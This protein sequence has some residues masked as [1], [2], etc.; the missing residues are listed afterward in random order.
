MDTKARVAPEFSSVVYNIQPSQWTPVDVVALSK[1][2]AWQLA[3]NVEMEVVRF[4]LLQN[5]TSLDRVNQIYPVY[6]SDGPVVLTTEDLNIHLT[7]EEIAALEKKFQ[8]DSG[9]FIPKVNK[10]KKPRTAYTMSAYETMGKVVQ[11]LFGSQKASNAWVVGGKFTST[12]GPVLANDPHM[13]FTAPGAFIL[14]HLESQESNLNTIG[15]SLVGIPGIYIGENA[16]ISWGLTNSAAD[17]QD[18]YVMSD[19]DG[20]VTSS[21]KYQYKGQAQNYNSTQETI[22]VKGSQNVVI[23]VKESVY[24]PVVNSLFDISES[25][26]ICLSYAGSTSSDLS[27]VTYLRIMRANNWNDFTAAVS[28]LAGPSYNF[29]YG[30]RNGNIGFATGGKI[31]IRKEGHSGRFPVPGT[32]DWDY[33]GF[34]PWNEMPVVFN[35]S[36]SYVVAA[37]NRVTPPG[38]KY[39]L[40]LDWESKYRAERI[41][42]HLNTMLPFSNVTVEEMKNLQMDVK[43][44]IFEEFKFIWPIIAGNLS[45]DAEG[46]REKLQAWDGKLSEGLEVPAI[47]EA[48]FGEM[49]RI[50]EQEIGVSLD[51]RYPMF[52]REVLKN[53]DLICLNSHNTTCTLYAARALNNSVA[54]LGEVFGGTA[55]L[56]GTDVHEVQF[57]HLSL[58][59][60]ALKCMA[61]KTVFNIGGSET[62]NVGDTTYPELKTFSGVTYRQVI[63]LSKNSTAAISDY[64]IIPLGQSGNWLA[65]TYDN[66]LY[67][68]R[69]GTYLDMKVAGYNKAA[70]LNLKA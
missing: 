32:G 46:W 15:A 54:A 58:G 25:S 8:N 23:T 13:A 61:T 5:G 4:K 9:A 26:S 18:L 44:M 41:V 42:Q 20:N 49:C 40:T 65:N 52:I 31:P 66:Y 57:N 33:L 51:K 50:T 59:D 56:W 10:N 37:N 1:A 62:V 64:F 39:S 68:W 3:L 70:V 29:V 19:V 14:M 2:F 47:F 34:I 21:T 7:P 28:N 35:P 63:D 69:A 24:G 17:L 48:W 16:Q 6:P 43:S 55:P 30:D 27:L 60:S 36:K 22:T 53:N 45:A 67:S 12:K 11:Q 38:Y